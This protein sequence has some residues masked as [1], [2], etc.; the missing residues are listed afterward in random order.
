MDGDSASVAP[1][2]RK[3]LDDSTRIDPDKLSKTKSDRKEACHSIKFHTHAA[4]ESSTGQ[5][6]SLTL[7][8]RP[9]A[10]QN[11]QIRA[12]RVMER[13]SSLYMCR[14]SRFK[15]TQPIRKGMR[16]S[17]SLIA[18]M[19]A[20]PNTLTHSRECEITALRKIENVLSAVNT[21]RDGPIVV[22]DEVREP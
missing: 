5:S 20:S 10:H 17:D 3:D 6:V 9:L 2:P 21:S 11:M 16:M 8:K 12:L 18:A 7:I 22:G 14:T 1:V 15:K 4:F 13:D 19:T